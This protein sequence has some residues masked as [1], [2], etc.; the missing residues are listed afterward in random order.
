MQ[1]PFLE[2]SQR[3]TVLT[4]KE[5]ATVLR[6]SKAHVHNLVAGRVHGAMLLPSI[7]LGR[8]RLVRRESLLAWLEQCEARDATI[9]SSPD[10]DAADA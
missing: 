1:T 10:I 5:V 6:C 2:E 4:V 8:R 9:R 3:S 7:Q